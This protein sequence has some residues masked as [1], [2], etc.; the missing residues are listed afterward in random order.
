VTSGS[1]DIELPV[2]AAEAW[3][4]L[5]A[6]G[7]RSWYFDLTPEGRFEE[8]GHVRW[9]DAAGRAAVETDIAEFKPTSRLGLRNRFVFAPNLAAMPPHESAWDVADT[10]SGCRIKTSWRAEEPVA[11][12]I[13]G[14]AENMLRGLR[15]ALDPA[16]R[17]A[18]ERLDFIGEV[19]VWDVTPDRV[20]DYQAF[21]DHEAFRDFPNWQ[22]CYCMETHRTQSDDE[23]ALRTAGDN[24]RD[25]SQAIEDGEVTALLAYVDGKP[26]G[27][28]NYGETTHLSGVMHRFGLDAAEHEGVGSVACFVIASRYRGHGVASRLLDAAIERLRARGLRAIEAYPSRQGSSA[29]AHYRGP[30]S[31]FLRAGFEP[32]RETERYLVVRKPL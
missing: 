5:V 11:A 17:A 8:G 15:L 10:P 28:C 25:M 3:E 19:E 29:Q 20:G 7:R 9:I 30:L 1:R 32:Y 2:S 14:D 27:W 23:W 24:R 4:A 21:F 26:A 16:A 31:M 13:E 22:F 12:M 18:I 6:P